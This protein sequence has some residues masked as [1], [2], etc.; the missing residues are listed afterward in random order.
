M[1]RLLLIPICLLSLNACGPKTPSSDPASPSSFKD[2][3]K[4]H[5]NEHEGYSIQIPDTWVREQRSGSSVVLKAPE[6][7]M[8][9]FADELS[10]IVSHLPAASAMAPSLLD[11]FVVKAKQSAKRQHSA[12]IDKEGRLQIAGQPAAWIRYQSDKEGAR[13]THQTWIVPKADKCF[14]VQAVAMS[15]NFNA[16]LPVFEKAVQSLQL[17]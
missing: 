5:I 10:V 1:Y 14:L 3:G 11:L 15:E 6:P 9:G 8:N 4:R 17:R 16:T 13:L 12:D 2:D 7:G